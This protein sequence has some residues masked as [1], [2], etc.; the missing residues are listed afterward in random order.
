MVEGIGDEW[1]GDWQP[2]EKDLALNLVRINERGGLREGAQPQNQRVG[3]EYTMKLL[4]KHTAPAEEQKDAVYIGRGSPL[5]NPDVIGKDG[6][7][8]EVIRK[9]RTYLANKIISRDPAIET[10]MRNLRP[11]TKLLCFC[12]PKPCHGSVIEEYYNDL[13]SDSDYEQSLRSFKHKHSLDRIIFNPEEDGV[14][15]INVY[16]KGKTPLG[17]SLSNFAHTPFEHP[18]DGFFSSV[19]G[20][21]YW[22]ST[23]SVRNEFRGLYGY[24]AKETGKLIREEIE[25]NG[26]LAIIE[27]FDARIKKAILC[28][29]EQNEELRKTLKSSDLPLTHYY[30][31]GDPPNVKITYPESYAWIHEYIADVR[32]WLNG[33]AFKL[34]IAGS[35]TIVDYTKVEEAFA[36]CGMKVI[37]IVS[38]RARGVDRLGEQVAKYHKLPVAK[39]PADWDK[40]GNSAGFIRNADM[41]KYCD[42]GL[43][44]WDGTST[45]TIDMQTKLE[46]EGKPFVKVL[47]EVTASA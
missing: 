14:T 15:H 32:D 21:W 1:L 3:K 22:L 38:G 35:R 47:I 2:T 36:N 11:D 31:W 7:R 12:H 43:L 28:K 34:L 42:A 10:A 39:F 30:T 4:N 25:R 18:E 23:G 40:L 29:I 19:E 46:K 41:A 16:S 5:G 44:L 33:K 13:M 24:K 20:Y 37:E 26:G 27:D 17:R 9:Y 8:E 45:G 6:T